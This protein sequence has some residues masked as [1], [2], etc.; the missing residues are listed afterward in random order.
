MH[1]AADPHHHLVEVPRPAEAPLAP[2]QLA[3]YS[4]TNVRTHARTVS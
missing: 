2:P 4:A 1:P 3:A